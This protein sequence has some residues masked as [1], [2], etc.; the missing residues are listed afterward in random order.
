MKMQ[1]KT[2]TATRSREISQ[3]DDSDGTKEELRSRGYA[4]V[5][6]LMTLTPKR[7]SASARGSFLGKE[8]P[9]GLRLADGIWPKGPNQLSWLLATRC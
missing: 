1:S 5:G 9:T 3:I 7:A 4:T 8:L 6:I 2:A